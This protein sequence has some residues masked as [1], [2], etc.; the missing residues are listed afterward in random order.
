MMT[1]DGI[2]IYYIRETELVDGKRAPIKGRPPL[3]CA[4]IAKTADGKICRG[5]S[6]R[7]GL[8][9]WRYDTG[10]NKAIGACR[11]A[12]GQKKSSAPICMPVIIDDVPTLMEAA[13]WFMS[14]WRENYAGSVEP[15]FKSGYD[16][17]PTAYEEE[18]LRLREEKGQGNPAPAS[19]EP[20]VIPADQI[21]R[22]TGCHARCGNC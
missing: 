13:V 9:N 5:I 7:S 8:D 2:Q 22:C 3:G 16:V 4:A 11:R 21:P 1:N 18:L 10:R 14:A 15:N 6:I 20:P 19:E 12:M 17:K